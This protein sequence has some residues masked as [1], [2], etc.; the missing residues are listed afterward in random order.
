MTTGAD[1]GNRQGLS[2]PK[3]AKTD[4]RKPYGWVA[5]G[6]AIG[7]L[8]LRG[9]LEQVVVDS[10]RPSFAVETFF[11]TAAMIVLI[12]VVWTF[13]SALLG[14]NKCKACGFKWKK[15]KA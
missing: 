9:I 6:I 11:A 12:A 15:G 2:C 3:C 8:V 13:F 1:A 5:F 4:I 7:A 14:K 10:G